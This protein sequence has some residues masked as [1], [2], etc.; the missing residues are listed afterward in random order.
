MPNTNAFTGPYQPKAAFEVNGEGFDSA[1]DTFLRSQTRIPEPLPVRTIPVAGQTPNTGMCRRRPWEYEVTAVIPCLNS[2]ERLRYVVELL[3]LQT[4]KPFILLIDTG[5]TPEQYAQIEQFRAQDLEVHS[6]RLNGVQNSSEP[7]SMA[8]DV[9]AAVCRTRFM[10][11]THDDVFL[12][13]R[14]ALQYFRDLAST[15]RLAGHALT[16]RPHDDW[17]GMF[18]HTALMIDMDWFLDHGLSWN[19]RRCVRMFGLRSTQPQG[20]RHNWPDT[21]MCLNYLCR[22]LKVKPFLTG[23]EKNFARNKDAFIDH[24]RSAGSSAVYSKDY[25]RMA[26]EWLASATE[27]AKKR[28]DEWLNDEMLEAPA[29]PLGPIKKRMKQPKFTVG[30]H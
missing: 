10:F 25:H 1:L 19:M 14:L 18:G 20:G 9:A 2:A 27:A 22:E 13:S 28:I 11:C 16:P 26:K 29:L 12:R 7:V 23:T 24:C 5:S 3:R 15:H 8:M 4:V 6:I 17:P 21:E 30:V